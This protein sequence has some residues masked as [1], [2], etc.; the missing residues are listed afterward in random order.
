MTHQ[1][2]MRGACA[3]AGG[4]GSRCRY[5]ARAGNHYS[6]ARRSTSTTART[7]ERNDGEKLRLFV[8]RVDEMEQ[9]YLAQNGIHL[10]T[11]IVIDSVAGMSMKSDCGCRGE[12]R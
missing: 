12:S 5:G 1:A 10:T 4:V 7:R 8:R 3:G 6:M 2:C 11:N 9:N